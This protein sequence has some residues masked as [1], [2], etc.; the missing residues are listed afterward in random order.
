MSRFV[1]MAH[2]VE[3]IKLPLGSY[4]SSKSGKVEVMVYILQSEEY[5]SNMISFTT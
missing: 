5:I 4:G 1:A 3:A 2:L